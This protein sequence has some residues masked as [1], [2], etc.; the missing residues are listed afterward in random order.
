MPKAK[1]ED[2]P[3]EATPEKPSWDTLKIPE[4]QKSIHPLDEGVSGNDEANEKQRQSELDVER[5]E[6]NRRTAGGDA[7]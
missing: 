5:D 3:V 4:A 6:H 2:K 7:R 1:P